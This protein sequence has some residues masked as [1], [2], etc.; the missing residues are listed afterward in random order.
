MIAVQAS[1]LPRQQC[2]IPPGRRA[3]AEEPQGPCRSQGRIGRTT[4]RSAS[5]SARARQLT[6]QANEREGTW[7]AALGCVASAFD[8]RDSGARVDPRRDRRGDD[9]RRPDPGCRRPPPPSSSGTPDPAPSAGT[10]SLVSAKT[11]PRKSFYYGIRTPALRYEIG[12]DQPSNDLR[13][14]LVGPG[15]EVIKSF[16]R[17]DVA[18]EHPRQRPLGRRDSRRSPRPERS[19]LVPDRA[20]G[21][22]PGGPAARSAGRERPARPASASPSTRSPSRF[23]ARTTSA[24][25][26]AGSAQGA[27]ATPTRGRT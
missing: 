17:N 2:R 10:L 12:S 24:P 14:D 16:Y 22:R 23:S 15:G 19:L 9:R 4:I 13:V 21:R 20:A 6:P 25:P 5:L 1:I 3:G 11:W 8:D 18:P 27:P 7:C 26:A